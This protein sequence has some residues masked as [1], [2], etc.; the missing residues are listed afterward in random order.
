[1]AKRRFEVSKRITVILARFKSYELRPNYR[2]LMGPELVLIW[3]YLSQFVIPLTAFADIEEFMM[4]LQVMGK[5]LK[6]SKNRF[7]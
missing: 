1:M 3:S 5:N 4:L 7:L 2:G 6:S